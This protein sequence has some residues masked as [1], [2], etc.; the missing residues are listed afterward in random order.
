MTRSAAKSASGRKGASSGRAGAKRA[1]GG[2]QRRVSLSLGGKEAAL[3]RIGKPAWRRLARRGG[4]S[5]RRSCQPPAHALP[6]GP[7]LPAQLTSTHPPALACAPAGV[8]RISEGCYDVRHGM[9]R[10]LADF[11]RRV[12]DKAV[13]MAE[14]AKRYTIIPNDISYA[15]KQLGM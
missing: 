8:L 10:A 9:P 5:R 14:Y 12:L 4:E 1:A 7:V 13:V 6:A 2:K 15:I 3:L 11:L